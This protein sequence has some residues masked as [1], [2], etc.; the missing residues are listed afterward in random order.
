M[1]APGGNAVFRCVLFLFN[2]FI[3]NADA[4]CSRV[5]NSPHAHKM[6]W[7]KSVGG[8]I[9]LKI[10]QTLELSHFCA[11][12]GVSDALP[13]WP[14]TPPPGAPRTPLRGWSR[15]PLPGAPRTPLPG[16]ARPPLRPQGLGVKRCIFIG[17]S[18]TKLL[19]AGFLSPFF[20]QLFSRFFRGFF[21]HFGLRFL[22]PFGPGGVPLLGMAT[23]PGWWPRGRPTS[24]MRMR[25]RTHLVPRVWARR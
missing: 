2:L 14:H 3:F 6:D 22:R 1:R 12:G 24:E 13:G 20:P 17:N 16:A 7:Q 15:T 25:E 23:V 19:W 18:H 21:T 5:P 4:R 11:S 9:S 8:Q 10:G